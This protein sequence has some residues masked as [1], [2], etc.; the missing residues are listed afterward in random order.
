MNGDDRSIRTYVPSQS[1]PSF[2]TSRIG[3]IAVHLIQG[4]CESTSPAFRK[5]TSSLC[6]MFSRGRTC[7]ISYMIRCG[8]TSV[9]LPHQVVVAIEIVRRMRGKEGTAKARKCH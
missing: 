5:R 4:C 3:V 8:P 9:Q 7:S 1:V 6:Y 2:T